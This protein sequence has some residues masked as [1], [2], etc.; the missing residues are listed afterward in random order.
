PTPSISEAEAEKC[1]GARQ[2]LYL[3][4]TVNF[5][6]AARRGSFAFPV[7]WA[8]RGEGQRSL[9]RILRGLQ[10]RIM[11][12]LEFEPFG[13]A[14]IESAQGHVLDPL[15]GQR[16]AFANLLRDRLAARDQLIHRHH[17]INQT[18]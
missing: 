10:P 2:N 15:H 6:S 5:E 8:F 12:A 3:S 16:C 14:P 11:L 7:W 1:A 9:P 4:R 18:Q 17:V 13:E